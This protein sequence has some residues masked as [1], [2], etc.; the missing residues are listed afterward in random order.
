MHQFMPGYA[1]A[2]AEAVAT[3]VNDPTR[4]EA[5]FSNG[6]GLKLTRDDEHGRKKKENGAKCIG[7]HTYKDQVFHI[8]TS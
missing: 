7:S 6:S 3:L 2:L 5:V 8:F 1:K 4:K